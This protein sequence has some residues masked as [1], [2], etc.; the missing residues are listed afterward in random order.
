MRTKGDKPA[1][2]DGWTQVSERGRVAG[3]FE[4]ADELRQVI[5]VPA[6]RPGAAAG[7][8]QGH[9]VLGHEVVEP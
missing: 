6:D 9:E 4:E 2:D 1:A 3:T 5:A 8:L 7:Y